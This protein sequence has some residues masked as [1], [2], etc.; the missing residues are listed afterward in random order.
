MFEMKHYVNRFGFSIAVFALLVVLCVLNATELAFAHAADQGF[1]LLLPTDVYIS[2][3]VIS[4]VISIIFVSVV[5]KKH[6]SPIFRPISFFKIPKF[7]SVSR[8]ALT[9]SSLVSS[10]VLLTVIAVG[11]FGSR[12]PLSNPL[13]LMIWTVWWIGIFLLQG[14]FGDIWRWL[15]PWSGLYLLVFGRN[16]EKPILTLP[17]SFEQWP[18]LGIFLLFSVFYLADPAPSD[19]HHLAEIVLGYWVFTFVALIIFGAKTWFLQGEIF[20]ILFGLISRLSPVQFSVKLRIGFPGWALISKPEF[21]LSASFICMALLGLG[22]FD[23]LNETF[24]WLG[25]LGVNPLEFPG[26]SAIINETIVGLIAANIALMGLFCL[27]VWLGVLFA[28]RGVALEDKVGLKSAVICFAPALLPI[29][30]GYHFAHFLTSILVNGQYLLIALADPFSTGANYLGLSNFQ[31]TTGF[32]TDQDIVRQIWLTQAG[33]VVVS[34]IL[35]VM[36]THIAAAKLFTGK[37][38]TII[39]ETPLSLFMIFYTLFGLWLLA[40]PKGA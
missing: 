2:S 21:T 30:F 14:L 34:H 24:W 10:M 37:L 25:V 17:A 27:C 19:P 18:A 35:A 36:L 40:A 31:V 7:K 20:T 13:P 15:N 11:M 33:A 26:K 5:S 32:F 3:G 22:S 9:V 6:L 4:V 8:T 1:V 28:N 29:A 16:D 38:K 23:G 12:D 39:G